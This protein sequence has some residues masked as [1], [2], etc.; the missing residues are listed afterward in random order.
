MV[1]EF[2]SHHALFFSLQ[3]EAAKKKGTKTKEGKLI[4]TS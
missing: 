1:D 2:Y 4:L 3:N